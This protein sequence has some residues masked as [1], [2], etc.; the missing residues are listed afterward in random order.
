MRPLVWPWCCQ[1]RQKIVK[2]K[3]K[4]PTELEARVAQ[5]IFNVEVR[6]V[7]GDVPPSTVCM[8]T[9]D[10][11]T[12]HTPQATRTMRAVAA[13][14]F[15]M[16]LSPCTGLRV[17]SAPASPLLWKAGGRADSVLRD[18][19]VLFVSGNVS[20]KVQVLPSPPFTPLRP[21]LTLHILLV[22]CPT[23][24]GGHWGRSVDPQ[25]W[26]VGGERDPFT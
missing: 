25:L 16:A 20:S 14:A 8:H 3:D 10:P 19:T 7:H 24:G 11:T 4:E 26:H 6:G 5:E 17:V 21:T 9:T 1:G 12:K 15:V 23:G 18:G 13:V 22:W 2:P